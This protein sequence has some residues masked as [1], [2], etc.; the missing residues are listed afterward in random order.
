MKKDGAGHS[1]GLG[2][3][4]ARTALM[5]S[6]VALSIDAMLPALGVIGDDLGVADGNDAQ[7]II[8]ALFLGFAV[9][10]LLFGPLSDSIGRKPAIYIGFAIFMVGCVLSILA[11]DL[12]VMLIG[13]VLQGVGAAGPRTVTVALVR[14][15]HEGRAMA[16]IMSMVMGVFI[17]V[18]AL[19]PALGQG[20]LLVAHWRWIFGCFLVL[21]T[22]SS[23]W[24][25]LRQPETLPS[26]K[27]R[28]F[29][30]RRT[31]SAIAETCT[32]RVA[33]GYTITG[34]FAF[35]AFVGY[36]VSA[37][38]IMQVQYGLGKLFPVYFGVLALAIGAA[39]FV[40]SNL[41]MR[42]GMRRLSFIATIVMCLM[43]VPFAG[44][45]QLLGADVPLWLFM[46][47]LIPLFFCIGILFGNFN[48]LAMEPLGHIAGVGAAVIGAF[49]TLISLIFGTLVG[50]LYDGTITPLVIGFAVLGVA[51][52][53]VMLWIERGRMA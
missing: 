32:N 2:E 3:F 24:F 22:I 35:G 10:Q 52:L 33:F 46:A 30:L 21:A 43:S 40:N 47:Y 41:V 37:Q 29:S 13:R 19:A 27:R 49:T 18:P 17:M 4:V 39:S 31:F 20:V 12:T 15:L 44:V 38:Q 45:C 53:G 8:S 50:Q 1:D 42:F 23:V 51:A 36:L 14:D 16:R 9:S 28:E 11:T 26:E 48:S 25:A 6:L 5:I 34:G 7:L